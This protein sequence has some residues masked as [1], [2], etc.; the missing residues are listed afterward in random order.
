VF[1]MGYKT[2]KAREYVTLF[3]LWNVSKIE[4]KDSKETVKQRV[5]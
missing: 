1:K 3:S 4:K 5:K 2:H